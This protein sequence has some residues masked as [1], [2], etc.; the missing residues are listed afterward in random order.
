MVAA[1][2]AD[3]SGYKVDPFGRAFRTLDWLF[4][5]QFCDPA[6]VRAQSK[7]LRSVHR[8]V[9]GTSP[10]GEP[11]RALDPE[12]LLWV[13]ATL[14]DSFALVYDTFVRPQSATARKRYYEEQKLLAAACGV[15]PKRCPATWAGFRDYVARVVGEDLQVTSVTRDVASGVGPFLRPPLSV[16]L[17]PLDRVVFLALLPDRLRADLGF[18]M[19]PAEEGLLRAGAAVSRAACRLSPRTVRQ[20][21][22]RYLTTR[23]QS[24]GLAP[25]SRLMAE[26]VTYEAR[27]DR[28]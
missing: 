22:A 27:S 9:V 25:P 10:G 8:R 11:Y 18:S 4:K 23:G 13:W 12:L 24:T 20:Q 7:L 2:V 5:V 19:G 26:P 1:G 15:P 17:G 3:H 21:P 6:T 28:R 16:L 14:V